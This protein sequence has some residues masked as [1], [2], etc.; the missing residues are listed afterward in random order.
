[1]VH[2]YHVCAVALLCALLGLVAL[3]PAGALSMAPPY[4]TCSNV[5]L[6]GGFEVSGNWGVGLGPLAPV[7]VTSPAYNSSFAMQMG[8]PGVTNQ[9]ANSWIFQRITIPNDAVSA[10]LSFRVWLSS[11]A[12][13]GADLQQALLMIPGA[14]DLSQPFQVLWS[15]QTN[16]PAWQKLPVSLIGQKGRALD[17]YFNV[18]ND[19]AGD[20]TA[21]VLDE[22]ELIICRPAATAFPTPIPSPLPSATPF[23]TPF[24][25][26]LPS[27]SPFPTPIPSPTGGATPFPTPAGSLTPTP[28]NCIQLISDGGFELGNAWTVGWDPLVPFY[29]S[30]AAFVRS[31]A[32]SMAQGSVNQAAVTT[33]AYSS[34]RQDVVVPLAA[35]SVTLTFWYYPFS[36]AT[37]MGLNRQELIL[38]DPL[39]FDETVKVLWRATENGQQWLA[40]QSYDLKEYRGR[41]LSVYFNARNAGDGAWTGMY[42]DDVSLLACG[43][44]VA[45]LLPASTPVV[46]PQSGPSDA[47]PSGSPLA[48]ATAPT[49]I[50]VSP[51]PTSQLPE[52]VEFTEETSEESRRDSPSLLDRLGDG[53]SIPMVVCGL[54][55]IVIVGLI[56]LVRWLRQRKRKKEAPPPPAEVVSEPPESF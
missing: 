45:T 26:P 25:T 13:A 46:A 1:M 32:R 42:L 37:P 24:P 33:P 39:A 44:A 54:T 3:P 4:Q 2:R 22:V 29:N 49:I 23:P 41:T 56:F 27:V 11:A 36:N 15:T 50:S 7:R 21:M 48:L 31:G 28:S 10:D 14:T 34:I 9:A 43:A 6:N 8:S 19:G 38:L 52:P 17:L 30:N 35:D 53:L 40:S 47:I 16:A 12:G 51:V 5:I 55:V 18:Y 20:G